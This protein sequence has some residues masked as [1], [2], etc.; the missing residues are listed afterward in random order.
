MSIL[1]LQHLLHCYSTGSHQKKI[2]GMGLYCNTTSCADLV[3]VIVCNHVMCLLQFKASNQQTS[4]LSQ[5]TTAVFPLGEQ[6]ATALT[7][8]ALKP[9]QRMVRTKILLCAIAISAMQ[10]LGMFFFFSFQLVERVITNLHYYRT[11]SIQSCIW[12][13]QFKIDSVRH[14]S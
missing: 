1:H 13:V 10:K 3:V 14:D 8:V 11:L 2:Q 9:P 4:V 5:L 7:H 12:N 6:M